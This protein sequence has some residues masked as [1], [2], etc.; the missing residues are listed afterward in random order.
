MTYDWA[1]TR[2]IL[3]TSNDKNLDKKKK[4]SILDLSKY[5][6]KAI[7]IK[8]QGGREATGILKGYDTLLNI[9]L[10]D[11]TEYLRGKSD[12]FLNYRIDFTDPDDP[13]KIT[14]FSRQLGLVVCRSSTIVSICP[15]DGME[16]IANPFIQHE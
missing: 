5:M 13:F 4:E 11:T 14:D 16:S 6:E 12:N 2:A 8:F 10:D 1:L 3:C 9:V 15:V 7:R